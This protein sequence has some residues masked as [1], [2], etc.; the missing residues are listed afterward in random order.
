MENPERQLSESWNAN[1]AAWTQSVRE[2]HIASRRLVTD[3]AVFD[4]VMSLAPARVLDAGCGEGWLARRLAANGMEVTGFDGSAPLIAKARESGGGRFAV[5]DY[6]AFSADPHR[7]GTAFD[8]VVFNFALL[9]EEVAPLL[10]AA[11]SILA[12]GGAIVIQTLHPA[13]VCTDE[14]YED[15]WKVEHFEGMGEGYSTPMPWYFRTL[16][17]WV[18]QVREAG[19]NLADIQEPLHP[20]TG[21][22]ASL[23]MV[24]RDSRYSNLP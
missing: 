19:L 3:Q 9:S 12:S 21:R 8:V 1:A 13:S 15:G 7:I 24:I 5:C 6:D 2:G 18:R 4:A 23:L 14:R 10:R 17:S 11:A 22:P 20:E 16:G